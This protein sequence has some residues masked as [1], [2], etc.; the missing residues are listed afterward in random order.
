MAKI[1][2]KTQIHSN[3]IRLKKRQNISGFKTIIKLRGDKKLYKKYLKKT[4]ALAQ[5]KLDKKETK[6]VIKTKITANSIIEI[7]NLLLESLIHCNF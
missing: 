5:E 7:F 6:L 2:S 1:Q 4:T 3:Q